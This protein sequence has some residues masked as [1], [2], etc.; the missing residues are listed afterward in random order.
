MANPILDASLASEEPT[1]RLSSIRCNRYWIEQVA[2][3]T[4]LIENSAN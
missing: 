2:D 3:V 1:R 4:L